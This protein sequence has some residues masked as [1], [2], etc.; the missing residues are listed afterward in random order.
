MGHGVLGQRAE[1]QTCWSLHECLQAYECACLCSVLHPTTTVA[2]KY[3]QLFIYSTVQ[4]GQTRVTVRGLLSD[5]REIQRLS[6]HAC[7]QPMQVAKV[8][9]LCGAKKLF[10][11]AER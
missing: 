11:K 2:A 4:T 8:Q 10:I 1:L 9:P 5:G 7:E 3:Q 6:V